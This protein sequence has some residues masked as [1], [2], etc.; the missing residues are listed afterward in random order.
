MT[1]VSGLLEQL[2]L[3][4]V[5]GLI[6]GSHH[7]AAPEVAHSLASDD[8]ADVWSVGCICLRMVLTGL[9]GVDDINSLLDNIKYTASSLNELTGL[10]EEVMMSTFRKPL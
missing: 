3:C 5:D 2:E 8:R 10:A 7:C 9:R 4:V 6:A 1:I